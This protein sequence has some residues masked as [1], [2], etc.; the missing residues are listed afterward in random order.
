M[1]GVLQSNTAGSGWET[2]HT[3]VVK[4]LIAPNGTLYYLRSDGW[5]CANGTASW[6]NTRDFAID[7][8][9]RLYWLGTGGL[10]Q[11]YI[12]A[13]G[14]ERLGTNVRKFA[15]SAIGTVY[16]LRGDDGLYAN[17]VKNW[18][19]TRDFAIDPAGRLYWLGTG[20]LLQ[21]YNSG[22]GWE[23]LGSNVRKFVVAPI[24]TVYDLRVDNWLYA[25][26]SK[27]WANTR[28]FAVDPAGRLYWHGNS[29]LLQ[30][31]TAGSDWETLAEW[32]VSFELTN[33][34]PGYTVVTAP[35]P[36]PSVPPTVPQPTVA[37]PT[38]RDYVQM[39]YGELVSGAI[40]GD[41]YPVYLDNF[42][43][44]V[45]IVK[46]ITTIETTFM[47]GQ[48]VDYYERE[49]TLQRRQRLVVD[50]KPVFASAQ[51]NYAI[52]GARFASE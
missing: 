19:N 51:Y 1:S 10:L 17:G 8:A 35:P 39:A 6:A 34:E 22:S 50:R 30:R 43:D 45:I 29:G 24:G 20:G 23:T 4:F 18:A 52:T 9:S 36:A 41:Y 25:N 32:V 12:P 7:P 5:L 42:S 47:N 3:D 14:W 37:Q 38:A 27:S 31:Y 33:L 13:S 40:G 11:R 49:Y 26:G 46:F 21:R 44:Q 2:L 15:V 48:S 16:D 28:D